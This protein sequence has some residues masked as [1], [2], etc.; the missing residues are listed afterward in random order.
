MIV[1]KRGVVSIWMGI[2]RKNKKEFNAYTKGM[3]NPDS[4]CPAFKDFGVDFIDSDMFIAYGTPA[5]KI[6]PVDELALETTANSKEVIADIVKKAKDMGVDEGNS[7][8]CYNHHEFIESE[9][10][11]LY[12]DLKFIGVFDNMIKRKSGR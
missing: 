5:N 6:I 4:D 1:D 2:S 11:K 12:N 8:Y 9:P 7:L 3:E 10:G